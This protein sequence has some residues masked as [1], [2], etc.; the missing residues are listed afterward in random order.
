MNVKKF[1]L[2]LLVVMIFALMIASTTSAAKAEDA[3]EKAILKFEKVARGL[4][5][6]KTTSPKAL[7]AHDALVT[8]LF[9]EMYNICSP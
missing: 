7:A 6:S 8:R 1:I 3:C 4:S 5:H 9:T 2:L